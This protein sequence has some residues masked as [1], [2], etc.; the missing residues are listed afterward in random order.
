MVSFTLL[1]EIDRVIFFVWLFD[2]PLKIQMLY[3]TS[4]T[5][6]MLLVPG[7]TGSAGCYSMAKNWKPFFA[8]GTMSSE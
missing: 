6:H 2:M 4:C 7:V 8:A 1:T 3:S 5:V